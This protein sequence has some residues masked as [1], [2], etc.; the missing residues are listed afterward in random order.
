MSLGKPGDRDALVEKIFKQ[1]ELQVSLIELTMLISFSYSKM[2][3]FLTT[4][5]FEKRNRIL[6]RCFEN[7]VGICK[8]STT[9][10]IGQDDESMT[11]KWQHGILSNYDYL[12]YINSLADRYKLSENGE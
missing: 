2:F 12:L 6:V 9:V 10:Q 8:N 1:P 7:S 5:N 4:D 11:L 3:D